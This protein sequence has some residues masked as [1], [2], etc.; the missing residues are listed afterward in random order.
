MAKIAI[1]YYSST[2]HTYQRARAIAEGAESVGAEVRVLKV[3][4]LAPDAA[5]DARP[6]WREHLAA[7]AE[8]PEAKIEDLEWADGFLFGTPTRF[9]LP[10]AQLKQFLDQCGGLWSQGKLQDKPVGVFGGAGNAHGGQEATLLALNN[11][12]YHWGSVIVPPGYTSP[13]FREA[14]G[15]PYGVSFTASPEAQLAT[16]KI[17]AGHAYGQRVAR[18]AKVL[19]DRRADLTAKAYAGG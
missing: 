12:F 6:G 17:A 14:G 7:T 16:A 19:A 13:L 5:I 8:V 1:V 11:T 4:E 9:G 18:F 15:N 2:S 10:A 3:A